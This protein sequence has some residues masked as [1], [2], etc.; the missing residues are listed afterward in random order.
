VEVHLK[1]PCRCSHVRIHV[2]GR[3]R[4]WWC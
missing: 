3:W 1:R 2:H 4:R